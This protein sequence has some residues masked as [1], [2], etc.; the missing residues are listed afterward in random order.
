VRTD[1]NEPQIRPWKLL[2]VTGRVHPKKILSNAAAKP[3]DQLVLTKP[4]GTG[5]LATAMKKG[6][7]S[8][9]AAEVLAAPID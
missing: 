8:A 7:L 6:T 4:I 9:S 1:A 5:L 2:S 3:G